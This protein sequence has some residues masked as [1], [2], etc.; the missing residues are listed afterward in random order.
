MQETTNPRNNSPPDSQVN[1][2]L[3]SDRMVNKI[4][5]LGEVSDGYSSN[6]RWLDSSLKQ[7]IHKI[8]QIVG[9]WNTMYITKLINI[10]RVPNVLNHPSTHMEQKYESVI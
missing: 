9:S 8:Q 3:N 10:V 6:F 2:I 5:S 7:E 1:K 4:K